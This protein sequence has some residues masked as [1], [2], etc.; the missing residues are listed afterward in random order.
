MQR[1]Q[2]ALVTCLIM[3][4]SP[5]AVNLT[6]VLNGILSSED[7]EGSSSYFSYLSFFNNIEVFGDAVSYVSP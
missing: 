1:V 5:V 6:E 4:L 3:N 2:A 7:E